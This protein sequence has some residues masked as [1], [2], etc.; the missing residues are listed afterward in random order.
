MS[1]RH[2]GCPLHAAF[3]RRNCLLSRLPSW[4]PGLSNWKSNQIVR[5]S[6]RFTFQRGKLCNRSCVVR[7]S[8]TL[9]IGTSEVRSVSVRL[10][11]S[12]KS[13]HNRRSDGS[14]LKYRLWW[15][16]HTMDILNF[17]SSTTYTILAL[18]V[19]F[20]PNVSTILTLTIHIGKPPRPRWGSLHRFLRAPS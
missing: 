7:R 5:A 6:I 18:I 3:T 13:G 1:K 2:N 12:G 14:Q 15:L 9:I 8:Y 20:Y 4:V 11:G 16:R 17:D 19:N 10:L